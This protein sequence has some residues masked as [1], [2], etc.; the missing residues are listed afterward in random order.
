MEPSVTIG[1]SIIYEE[2]EDIGEDEYATMLQ[3]TLVDL[4]AGGIH[5]GTV[6]RVEDFTQDLEVDICIYHESEWEK[7][8]GE[9][10][11]DD[12]E[13]RF[14]IGGDKPVVS[15]GMPE[16]K[17]ASEDAH[18]KESGSDVEF[19]SLDETEMKD[20]GNE[21]GSLK[22][23]LDVPDDVVVVEGT[24]KKAKISN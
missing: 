13:E 9:D 6:I 5:H 8:E 3:K 23:S 11:L 14:K 19:V 20:N 4:P 22:R 21:N 24:T 10:I 1:S 7:G 16:V 12:E 18:E 2:G 17:E 15:K